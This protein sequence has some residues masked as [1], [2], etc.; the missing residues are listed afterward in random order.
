MPKWERN[1][2]RAIEGLNQRGGRMLSL[3]DLIKAGTLD[4]ELA[5]RLAFIVS[6]G[7]SFVTAAGPGGTGKTTLM[8]ALLAF[9]PP[10]TEI[11]TVADRRALARLDGRIPKHRQCLLA[12]ELGSGHYLGYLWGEA[13]P[14]YFARIGPNRSL[15]TNLHAVRYKEAKSI[16][17]GA[18][19]AVPP[20]DFAKL[21]LLVFMAREGGKRRVTEAWCC[22]GKGNHL[23]AWK[24]LFDRDG[25]APGTGADSSVLASGAGAPWRAFAEKCGLAEGR[26]HEEV[27]R[28]RRFLSA[29]LKDDCYL[30]SELRLRALK[31]IY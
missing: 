24:W 28:I 15:C 31:E 25:G 14:Q 9:V 11:V 23:L 10:G 26:M 3:V 21:D 5:A 1:N 7:G 20:A 22:D 13:V 12:H 6:S 27:A 18:E 30:L 19:L 16:L 8:G 2:I 17:T 29:A 4:V